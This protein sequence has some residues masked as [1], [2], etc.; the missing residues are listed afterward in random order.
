MGGIKFMLNVADVEYNQLIQTISEEGEWDTGE[1]VRG[2]YEDGSPAYTKSIFGHQVKFQNGAIPLITSKQVFVKTATK[3]AWLFWIMQTVQEKDFKNNKVKIWDEWYRNGHLGRSYAYQFESHRHHIREVVKVNKKEIPNQKIELSNTKRNVYGVGYY[4]NYKSVKNYTEYE[5]NKLMNI[6]KGMLSRCYNKN[7]DKYKFYGEL[8]VFVDE[9]WHSFEN[10]LR[11]IRYLPQFFLAKECGFKNWN[12]DK[13]FY[14]SNAYSKDTCVWLTIKENAMYKK[15]VKNVSVIFENGDEKLFLT[16]KDT[17]TFLSV[18]T[19]TVNRWLL[20][21]SNSYLKYGIKNIN[22]IEN[23]S[24]SAFRY[25]LSRNQVV[26]L[27]LNIKNNPQSRRLMTSFWNDA[28][29]DKKQLQECAWATQSNVKNNYFDF[30][31]IQRSVDTGLGLPFNWIQYWIIGNVIAHVNNLQFRH[32]THQMGNVHYYDRHEDSLLKQIKQE[33]Y[34]TPIIE[35]NPNL[36]D[37]FD[38]T[39]DDVIIKEYKH[40]E[41]VPLEVAI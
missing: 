17:A 28:D 31:L 4:G 14:Q 38:F 15:S 36:K 10:F 30:M 13:D 19:S 12:L 1:K 34:S 23:N 35:I 6:W 2:V 37:F 33:T 9:R 3:E 32:F 26:D 24:D 27:L 16:A 21:Q 29:V 20:Q 22:Y 40:G 11:D 25:E 41:F 8:G 18:G 5:V 7:K 39:P